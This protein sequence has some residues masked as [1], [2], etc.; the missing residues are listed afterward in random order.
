[1]DRDSSGYTLN[2]SGTMVTPIQ[3]QSSWIEFAGVPFV[4]SKQETVA[5]PTGAFFVD[6]EGCALNEP[7]QI[8]GQVFAH[9]IHRQWSPEMHN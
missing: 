5:L 9:Q 4:D 2:Y 6:G 7:I 8:S 3:H 1:M